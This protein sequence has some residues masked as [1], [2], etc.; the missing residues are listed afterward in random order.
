VAGAATGADAQWCGI[1]AAKPAAEPA[2]PCKF[3][4]LPC[5]P[6]S[7]DQIRGG[8]GEPSED[9]DGDGQPD[10]IV[11]GRRD[12]PK[13]ETYAVIYRF[14]EPGY[15]LVDYRAMPPRAEPT[16]ATVVLASPGSA[17]LIRDGYDQLESGGRTLSIARL[18]RF[19]GQ[20]FRT[21]LTF[22]AHRVEPIPGGSPR[23]GLNRVE[24]VD[25]D[26]DGSKEVVVQGLIKPT[27]FRQSENGL[28][29]TE[30]PAL[31]QLY[32]DSSPE[33][34]R[35]KTLRAEAARHLA[36]GQARRAADT[37]QRAYALASYD[38]D[39]GGELV[40]A[41]L[42]SEQPARAVE[43]LTRLK[44]QAPE[45]AALTCQLATAQRALH[46]AGAEQAALKICVESEPDETLRA[47]A[48]ARLR[49]LQQGSAP[50]PL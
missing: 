14:T 49:E 23:E 50:A 11:G 15:V 1:D 24:F 30:D 8:A 33:A 28:A 29:L 31:S 45:R 2:P 18:R 43:I 44:H 4:G 22:C 16:F 20:R 6:V 27:V 21:L 32:L 13:P 5:G 19:D 40:S 42:R 34:Q 7:V 37:L 12:V 39:L 38:L 9:L 48:L 26:K 35:A 47:A 10:L 46:D 25:V 41:L 36:A 17:P 3:P